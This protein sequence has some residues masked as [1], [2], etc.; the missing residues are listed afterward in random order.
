MHIYIYVS[1]MRFVLILPLVEV[2]DRLR[3]FHTISLTIVI[4]V[5]QAKPV[6]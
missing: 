4:T 5:D 3:R 2:D 1:Y 6:R